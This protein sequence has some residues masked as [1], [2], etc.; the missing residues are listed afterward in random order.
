MRAAGLGLVVLLLPA[1]VRGD[2]GAAPGARAVRL[3]SVDGQVQL[4]QSG[5]VVTDHAVANTPLFEGAQLTTG[6]D[7][8]T[9]IQFED[10]SVAR[11][12]PDSSLTITALKATGGTELELTSGMG[13]FEIKDGNQG[14]PMVVRFA[15]SSVTVTGF[16][17]LRVKLDKSPGELAVFSGNAHLDGQAGQ[18]DV[19]GGESVSLSGLAVA[20]SIEPDSWDAWNGDRDQALTASEAGQTEATQGLPNSGN[21]AWGDLNSNGTWY[22][23]PDQGYVWS[24]YEASNPE[25]DPYGSG[26]WVDEP[27][28]GYTYVSGEPW[29]YMPYQCG[30]WNWYNTFGWGWA[31]GM[32]QPWWGTGGWFFTIGNYP[33]WYRLPFRP[34]RRRGPRP[35]EPRAVGPRQVIP[36]RRTAGVS[37]D[38]VLPK[39]EPGTP[40]RIGGVIARPLQPIMPRQVYSPE[41]GTPRPGIGPVEAGG[42]PQPV[43]TRP[44]YAPTPAPQRGTYAPAPTPGTG[45]SGGYH[46]A[47]VTPR[48]APP[49]NSHPSGGSHPSSGSHPAPSS[50]HPASTSSP[51][52]SGGGGG[53]HGGGSHK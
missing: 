52:A 16:T 50:P 20:E 44:V 49:G 6:E 12:P 19:H 23:V 1:A 46:P 31:P 10:G 26:S 45:S 33:P 48:P 4:S 34:I 30:A 53:S 24:P 28:Y 36:V 32:C 11:I 15:G 14:N 7:G 3:S 47:P 43:V 22:N 21:P 5:Q 38:A 2:D 9:E 39:R 17:V 40:I 13:F 41:P 35:G 29:G 37:P 42:T 25:W 51:H 18:V 8:R 27:G